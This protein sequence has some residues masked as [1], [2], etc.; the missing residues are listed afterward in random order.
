METLKKILIF[1]FALEIVFV[2]HEYGHYIEFRKKDIAV[3]EFSIGIGPAIYQYKT[4]D[5]T[6][7]LR[8]IPIM[9]YVAPTEDGQKI[10]EQLSLG[11]KLKIYSAGAR[12]NIFTGVMTVLILNFISWRKNFIEKSDLI[13]RTLYYPIKSIIM[14]LVF[15]LDTFTFRK[16]NLS[17]NFSLSSGN[18]SPPRFV[19]VFIYW[20]FFLGFLNIMPLYPLDGG[21]IF[22][23]VAELVLSKESLKAIESVSYYTLIF[24]AL[25]FGVSRMTFVNYED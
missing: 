4:G 18:I 12:N 23:E 10:V 15:V 7:S 13:R 11:D 6:L 9:A 17:E 22:L 20:C 3:Q 16:F 25:I 21:K 19:S 14:V 24:F 2:I 1:L 5:L 8:V